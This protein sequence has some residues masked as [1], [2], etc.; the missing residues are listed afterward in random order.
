[1]EEKKEKKE[2]KDSNEL[3]AEKLDV[4]IEQNKVL[5]QQDHF[6]AIH[7]ATI[8]KDLRFIATLVAIDVIFAVIAV[9]AVNG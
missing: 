3:I 2:V 8:K 1:M 5:I 6:R 7:I 9:L 4:I